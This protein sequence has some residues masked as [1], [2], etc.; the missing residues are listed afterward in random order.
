MKEIIN[1]TV[2]AFDMFSQGILSEE[3]ISNGIKAG[4]VSESLFDEL[5]ET[6][7]VE[8]EILAEGKLWSQWRAYRNEKNVDKMIFN[9]QKYA[10]RSVDETDKVINYLRGKQQQLEVNE[11]NSIRKWSNQRKI[12]KYETLKALRQKKLDSIKK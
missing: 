5:V 9:A 11:A 6:Y 4:L 3:D 1:E 7:L 2:E 12:E 8:K 10:Q